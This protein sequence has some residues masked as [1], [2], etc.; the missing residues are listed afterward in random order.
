MLGGT[1]Y[2]FVLFLQKMGQLSG[3]VF[4][5]LPTTRSECQIGSFLFDWRLNNT[6]EKNSMLVLQKFKDVYII[7]WNIYPSFYPLTTKTQVALYHR[8]HALSFRFEAPNI[9]L[10]P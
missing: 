7:L 3:S 4:T 2:L 5:I 6:K 9:I 8:C 1:N 10:I